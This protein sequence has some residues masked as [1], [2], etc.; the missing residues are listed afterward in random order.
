[1]NKKNRIKKYQFLAML[2]PVNG[3]YK[4][5]DDVTGPR[6]NIVYRAVK[7]K[8]NIKYAYKLLKTI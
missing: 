7:Q 1:M 4:L 5:V 3:L 2:Q 8:V 6:R